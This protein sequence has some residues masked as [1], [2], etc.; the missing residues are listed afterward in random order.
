[1][2]QLRAFVALTEEAGLVQHPQGSSQPFNSNSK[3]TFP[4][5]CEHHGHMGHTH[6]HAGYAYTY[7]NR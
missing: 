3:I 5:L 1:M 4:D 7:K 6:I 2:A